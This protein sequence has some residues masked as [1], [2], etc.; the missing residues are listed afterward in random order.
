MY[1]WF[2][3][4]RMLII[5]LFDRE[6]GD[7]EYTCRPSYVAAPRCMYMYMG[8]LMWFLLVEIFKII[9]EI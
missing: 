6:R 7:W 9:M 8:K 2:K 3:T 5:V 1:A 4:S